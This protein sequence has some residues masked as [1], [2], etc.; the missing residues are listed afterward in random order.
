MLLLRVLVKSRAYSPPAPQ[1]LFLVLHRRLLQVL[2]RPFPPASLKLLVQL[3]KA[4]KPRAKFQVLRP[5]RHYPPMLN[6][7]NR[8]VRE[9]MKCRIF[10]QLRSL[11]LYRQALLVP[12][13]LLFLR[14][15]PLILQPLVSRPFLR[16]SRRVLKLTVPL[17]FLR[18]NR[19]VL[20]ARVSLLSLPLNRLKLLALQD[21][22]YPLFLRLKRLILQA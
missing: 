14:L 15:T 13:Y 19:R 10:L 22:V 17:L 3:R 2:D 11:Q 21:R 5:R 4:R 18:L 1:T 8:L 6:L 12:V 9:Q 16:L 7:A 20:Q